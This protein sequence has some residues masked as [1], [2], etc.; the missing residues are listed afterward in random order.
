MYCTQ[1][2]LHEVHQIC[3]GGKFFDRRTAQLF[4]VR[5]YHSQGRQHRELALSVPGHE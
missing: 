5:Q 1:F 2:D 3:G 4:G